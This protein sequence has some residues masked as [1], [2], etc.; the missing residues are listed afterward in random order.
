MVEDETH[1]W[2]I[3]RTAGG[4]HIGEEGTKLVKDLGKAL[5]VVPC[6]GCS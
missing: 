6:D 3:E 1:L 4:V 5:L 2:S